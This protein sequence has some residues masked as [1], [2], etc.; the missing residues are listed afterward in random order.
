MRYCCARCW[1]RNSQAKIEEVASTRTER[2][3]RGQYVPHN[4]LCNP[5]AREGH[6]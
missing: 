1:V 2:N 5:A 3:L 6:L 4:R